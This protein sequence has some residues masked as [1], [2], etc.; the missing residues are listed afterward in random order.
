[1]HASSLFVTGATSHWCEA[2][3]SSE[4]A[5]FLRL[6]PVPFCA[7]ST[8][9]P[10]EWLRGFNKACWAGPN[11]VQ[12]QQP[13]SKPK[14]VES[15]RIWIRCRNT[16]KRTAPQNHKSHKSDITPMPPTESDES[17]AFSQCNSQKERLLHQEVR[18]FF[19]NRKVWQV[20]KA[21]IS[22]DKALFPKN[23]SACSL[24]HGCFELGLVYVCCFL[25][26]A[27]FPGAARRLSDT[28]PCWPHSCDSQI[29]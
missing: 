12:V 1:M 6:P 16:V 18:T 21:N 3:I 10:A 9:R 13:E 27:A 14:Y 17:V 20:H 7:T 29:S 19:G 5:P 25:F 23:F 2:R 4:L 22:R 24:D 8:T 26:L 15:E 28:A 11:P